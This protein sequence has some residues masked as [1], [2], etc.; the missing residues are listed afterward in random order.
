M[1]PMPER[2]PDAALNAINT[3]LGFS[4]FNAVELYHAIYEALERPLEYTDRPGM[5]PGDGQPPNQG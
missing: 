2:A 3:V 4:S 1:R 5:I